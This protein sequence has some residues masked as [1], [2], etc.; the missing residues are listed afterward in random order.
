MSS[1]NF[2]LHNPTN[3]LVENLNQ[4]D[5]G[6]SFVDSLCFLIIYSSEE[7]TQKSILRI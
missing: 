5:T 2:Y 1:H 7:N 3:M 4:K 6:Y